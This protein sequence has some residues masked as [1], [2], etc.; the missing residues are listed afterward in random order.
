MSFLIISGG[1]RI[2]KEKTFFSEGKSLSVLPNKQMV[3]GT[4][5]NK[6]KEINGPHGCEM[7]FYLYS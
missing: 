5:S 2:T 7:D 3:I 4:L 1:I 6:N